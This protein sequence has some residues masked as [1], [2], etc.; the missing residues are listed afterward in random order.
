MKEEMH[1]MRLDTIL[2][3]IPQCESVV[4]VGADH[5]KVA[6]AAVALQKAKYA[7][8]TDIGEGPLARAKAAIRAEG[9]EQNIQTVLTDGLTGVEKHSVAVVAGMGGEL[10]LHILD[11]AEWTK[12]EDVTFVLQPMTAG[13]RLRPGLSEKGYRIVRE[14]I[15]QEGEKLYPVLLVRCGKEKIQTLDQHWLSTAG[16]SSPLAGGYLDKIISRLKKQ[17]AGLLAAEERDETRISEVCA[18]LDALEKRRERI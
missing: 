7:T 10:I 8:A 15:A 16:E 6:I 11:T 1:M 9:L 13:E 2:S 12:D 5:A 4:D 18:Y 14:E 17:Y 3:L